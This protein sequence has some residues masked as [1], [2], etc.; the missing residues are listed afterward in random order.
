MA[1]FDGVLEVIDEVDESLEEDSVRPEDEIPGEEKEIEWGREEVG[2]LR[3]AVEYFKSI[4][5]SYWMKTAAIFFAKQA[6]IGAILFGVMYGLK[7]FMALFGNDTAENKAKKA[8]LDGLIKIVKDISNT[9][10]ELS[11]WLK[12]HENDTVTLDGIQ[13]PLPDIFIKYTK[14]IEQV[15]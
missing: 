13:V 15:L 11:A 10:K 6:A 4:R 5:Y 7:K 1:E 8:K 9:S 2:K 12:K 3:K 14:P